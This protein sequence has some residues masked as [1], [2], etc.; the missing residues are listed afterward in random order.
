MLTWGERRGQKYTIN[1]GVRGVVGTRCYTGGTPAST[2]AGNPSGQNNTW[3]AGGKQYNDSIWNTMEIRV[4]PKVTGQA[5]QPNT[6]YDIYFTNSF[7]NI[8]EPGARRR[9]PTRRG[10]PRASR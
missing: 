10:S 1:I 7:Q 4:A 2:A 5:N 6:A 8:V 9:R 3:Y